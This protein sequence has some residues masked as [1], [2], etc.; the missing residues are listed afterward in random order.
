[1]SGFYGILIPATEP[2]R[3]QRSSG[4]TES[5]A[6]ESIWLFSQGFESLS[7]S[8][9]VKTVECLSSVWSVTVTNWTPPLISLRQISILHEILGQQS[10]P[11]MWDNTWKFWCTFYS[12]FSRQPLVTIAVSVKEKTKSNKQQC[13]HQGL[14]KSMSKQMSL[15]C[16]YHHDCM[17]MYALDM[18]ITH[19]NNFMRAFARSLEDLRNWTK[20]RQQRKLPNLKDFYKPFMHGRK[21]IFPTTHWKHSRRILILL[22]N[23]YFCQKC[24]RLSWHIINY[25]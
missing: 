10:T 2:L 14:R 25:W 9:E 22:T 15:F 4:F 21:E 12:S 20:F 8:A 1:M 18:Q 3:S 7:L 16:T 19:T 6:S 11:S 23:C 24:K 17:L 5:S 13:P